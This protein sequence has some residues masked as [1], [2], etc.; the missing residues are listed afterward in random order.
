[1][2]YDS[3]DPEDRTYSLLR[4]PAIFMRQSSNDQGNIVVNVVATDYD[5][6]CENYIYL[7][8]IKQVNIGTN[9]IV[10]ILRQH[11]LCSSHSFTFCVIIYGTK[12][13]LI[14]IGRLGGLPVADITGIIYSVNKDGRKI[15]V[16]YI[17]RN[18]TT[19]KENEN[20]SSIILTD[21][22]R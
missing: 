7:A 3:G 4:T 16:P 9:D 11:C 2:L 22:E 6:N 20:Y 10:N 17:R 12:P 19:Y 8:V 1:M 18:S 14:G 5:V 13:I 21:I 15:V